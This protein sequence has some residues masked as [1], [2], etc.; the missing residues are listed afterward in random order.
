MLAID[1]HVHITPDG[2]WFDT[3][4]DASVERLLREMDTAKVDRAVLIPLPGAAGN[5]FIAKTCRRHPDRLLGLALLDPAWSEDARERLLEIRDGLGLAGLKVHPR[6]QNLDPNHPALQPVLEQAG[7]LGLPVVFCTYPG[8][9]RVPLERLSPYN[10]DQL[11]KRHGGTTIVLAHAGVHRVMDAYFTAKANPNVYL[12]I[13][14]V[15]RYLQDTSLIN[16]LAWVMDKLDQ[17]VIYGSDFPE[18]SLSQYKSLVEAAASSRP[19]C[20]LKAVMG[21]NLK[22]LLRMAD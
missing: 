8:P 2:R 4:L 17:R 11:A 14:H 18:V 20:D 19:D 9:C 1:A 5:D 21:G 13:S 6:R 15:F 3:G 7:S 10:Y 12:E 16:D 22:R